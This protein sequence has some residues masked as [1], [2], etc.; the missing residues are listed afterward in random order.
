[1]ADNIEEQSKQNTN[2]AQ[3]TPPSIARVRQ[4]N[5]TLDWDGI[6][7]EKL[8]QLKKSRSS[9]KGIVT[10]AQNEI[11][12]MMLNSNNTELVKGRIE[13]FKQLMQDFKDTHT[14]YHSQL[15]DEHEIE[16]SNDYYDAVTLL[17]SDLARDVGNWILSQTRSPEASKLEELRPEDSISNA[18]SR[19]S[20]RSS[21][22]SRRSSSAGS[23]TSSISAAKAKAAAKRAV[24]QAEA[25]NLEKFHTLQKEE[26]SLQLRKRAL[27]LQTEIEKAQAEELVY[28][29]AKADRENSPTPPASIAEKPPQGAGKDLPLKHESPKNEPSMHEDHK[30]PQ[31]STEYPDVSEH[32]DPNADNRR[33]DNQKPADKQFSQPTGTDELATENPVSSQRFLERLLISQSHQ[34]SVMHQLLQRQ[35][36]STL[37]LTLPQPDVPT[38]SGDPIEYWGFVR[39][40]QN[41]IESK[42]NSESARLYY[43]VQY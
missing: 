38:F 23:R 28:A 43:L 36:E 12:D 34:N 6:R 40:F 2:D 5:T 3:E 25:A 33:P 35:Q 16:E 9:K 17:A 27:E 39:A 10:K 15:R 8:L 18:G 42:T 22:H 19:V 29:E 14:A 4:E 26:L 31:S 24:L 7:S 30:P 41:L 11:K 13:E 21:R 1:M 20:S 32:L 37:A